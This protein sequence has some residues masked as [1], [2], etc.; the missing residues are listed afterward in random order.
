MNS[1]GFA[2]LT[3]TPLLIAAALGWQPGPAHADPVPSPGPEEPDAP[4]PPPLP[5][6]RRL[7]PRNDAMLLS[8][9]RTSNGDVVA[10]DLR[11]KAGVPVFRSARGGAALTLGYTATHLELPMAEPAPDLTLHR[12]EAT[13][14][15]GGGF[16]PDWSLRGALGVAYAS[17]LVSAT[18]RAVTATATA[19]VQRVLGPSDA[20]SA[21]LVYLSRSDLFPVLPAL[22]YVHQREGSP[23]RIDILLPRYAR[24]EYRFAPRAT[25]ALGV[26][27]IAGRWAIESKIASQIAELEVKRLGGVGFAELE[28]QASELVR[29]QA[30]LGLAFT[31]YTLPAETAGTTHD[32]SAQLGGVAQLGVVV[33]P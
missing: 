2:R 33:V 10:T 25:A 7:A 19:S 5:V 31:R 17:D 4:A 1:S 30:R 26:E 29:F 12:F 8:I 14:G 32:G 15:G 11:V 21:G 27:F 20:V 3:T 22:G 28:L 18:S 24:A 23:L 6:G 16:A 13:L 9:T